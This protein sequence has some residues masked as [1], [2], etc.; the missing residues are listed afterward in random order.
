MHRG[1]GIHN[2]LEEN[3][4]AELA[5][6]WFCP[7]KTLW[8]LNSHFF[9]LCLLFIKFCLLSKK[10]VFTIPIP[11]LQ[12]WKHR[13]ELGKPKF[14]WF[15]SLVNLE[16]KGWKISSLVTDSFLEKAFYLLCLGNHLIYY[17]IV[18]LSFSFGNIC[19]REEE[20]VLS[21]SYVLPWC[22]CFVMQL[23]SHWNHH[24]VG[25]FIGGEWE[26]AAPSLSLSPERKTCSCSKAHGEPWIK[27]Q[28]NH[29]ISK[30]TRE[31][32]GMEQPTFKLESV[33]CLSHS[34]YFSHIY[35]LRP[36]ISMTKPLRL[37]E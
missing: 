3:G 23:G 18:H 27:L 26:R 6:Q 25:Y 1:L 17:K 14:G 21:W 9:N 32:I 10:I 24:E 20:N 7:S 8:L 37:R 28:G 22:V 36:I 12:N 29:I 31:N 2:R 33:E 19:N 30:N 5:W 13:S 16:M 35:T 15:K 4:H 34:R 11:K